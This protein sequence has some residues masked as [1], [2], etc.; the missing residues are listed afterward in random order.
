MPHNDS[1]HLNINKS[2]EARENFEPE[3]SISPKIQTDN[4]SDNHDD[5]L[6]IEGHSAAAKNYSQLVIRNQK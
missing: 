2:L 6:T 4:S 3:P 5:N 1:K